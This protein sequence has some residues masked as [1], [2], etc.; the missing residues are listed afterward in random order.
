MRF[1]TV[2]VTSHPK[3][4]RALALTSCATASL[5]ATKRKQNRSRAKRSLIESSPVYLFLNMSGQTPAEILKKI[6][7]L[8]IKTRGLVQ[9]TFAGDYHSVF[10]GRGMNFED[11]REYQP[12]D[13]IRAIDW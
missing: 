2:A 1:S 12:G 9:E 6:R 10:K 13:E 5:S 11:V 7:A 3:T 8:E 4:L